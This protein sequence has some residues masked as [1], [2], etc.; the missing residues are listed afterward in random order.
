[1]GLF[2]FAGK[3]KQD[4][5][6]NDSEFYSHAEEESTTVRRRR[7]RKQNQEGSDPVLPEKKR[8]RR[9]L[10]GAVA[11]V[12]AAVIGLPMILDSEPK[13][14]A[15]DIAI[16]IPSKDKPSTQMPEKETSSASSVTVPPAASLDKNEEIIEPPAKDVPASPMPSQQSDAVPP[17]QPE[18]VKTA[19]PEA[20]AVP[21]NVE[22]SSE[23][24]RV[25][26]LLEGQ[27]D[28]G[29][30]K[31]KAPSDG[32]NGKLVIQVA[33]LGSQDKVNELQNK[34]KNAGIKSYTSKVAT[35][36]GE[37]IRVRIGPFSSKEEAEKI[38]S[39]LVKLGLGGTLV[40]V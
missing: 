14:L 10:V 31:P 39:K 16:E 27:A 13:P 24:E 32:K 8:A 2:S 3:T 23:E 34:L 29:G 7:K 37:R 4:T 33:A 17:A 35:Q 20:R 9:R 40:P 30:E 36:S 11:L 26:A 21:K 5:V 28:P 1:M 19:Q 12:L 25:R 38:R 6:S 15:S 22:K 18:A